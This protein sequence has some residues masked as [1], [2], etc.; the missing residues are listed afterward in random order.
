[1][2]V[3]GVTGGSGS[4]IRTAEFRA[5]VRARSAEESRL[6]KLL[7]ETACLRKMGQSIVEHV[8]CSLCIV[9]GSGGKD[10]GPM[11]DDRNGAEDSSLGLVGRL[12]E[13][14]PWALSL[15][16]VR[17]LGHRVRAAQYCLLLECLPGR[18]IRIGSLGRYTWTGQ[19]VHRL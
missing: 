19:S 10:G 8:W 16:T 13:G 11:I 9:W 15:V 7:P 6:T 1:M 18:D 2:S 14:R 4:F 17:K 12:G 3:W 5:W